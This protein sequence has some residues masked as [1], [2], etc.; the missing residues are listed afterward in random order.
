FARLK[1]LY[2][3]A[4]SI[5]VFTVPGWELT[6]PFRWYVIPS[7]LVLQVLLLLVAR[8]P[9]RD[10]VR[11]SFRLRWLFAFLIGCYVFLP[12]APDLSDSIYYW[13]P[14]ASARA[15]PLNLT[16]LEISLLMCL[17]IITV[18]LVSAVVRLTG[19]PTDLVQGLHGFGL[20][21]LLVHSI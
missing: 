20:P 4:V 15:I 14:F 21:R 1:V 13:Q 2:L 3:L 5:V 18:I 12:G 8:I 10:I 6:R 7:L 17:Q 16:G 19:A 9:V 11:M